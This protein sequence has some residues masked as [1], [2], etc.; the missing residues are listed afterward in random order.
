MNG[1]SGNGS[2][3]VGK[4]IGALECSEPERN[5]RAPMR[6]EEEGTVRPDP[7]VSERPKHMIN[8]TT[9]HAEI[10]FQSQKRKE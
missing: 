6:D 9:S 10:P 3:D 7:E 2:V 4:E 1:S 8:K 5:A